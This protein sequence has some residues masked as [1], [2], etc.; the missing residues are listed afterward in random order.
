MH[1]TI[2][3]TA[4]SDATPGRGP[5]AEISVLGA[6]GFAQLKAIAASNKRAQACGDQIEA[7][8]LRTYGSNILAAAHWEGPLFISRLFAYLHTAGIPL[9]ITDV[10]HRLLAYQHLEGQ[11]GLIGL[12]STGGI[13]WYGRDGQPT[14]QHPV[15]RYIQST[16]ARL[17][18]NPAQHYK[19]S[20]GTA[21]VSQLA[22][23]GFSVLDPRD[24]TCQRIL[25]GPIFVDVDYGIDEDMVFIYASNG[26][27]EGQH[28]A[29]GLDEIGL[30]T[31]Q[32]LRRD[33]FPIEDA[34]Q[35]VQLVS[36]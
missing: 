22:D 5:I 16:A 35:A 28:L 4:V 1:Q 15:S 24:R 14:D 29:A 13:R 23:A 26:A 6:N 34:Q 11:A 7:I 18:T 31:Y 12:V 10:K 20:I 33:G 8:H 32:I 3:P 9:V 27:C 21:V 30:H 19:V 2:Q 17:M 25:I 36:C